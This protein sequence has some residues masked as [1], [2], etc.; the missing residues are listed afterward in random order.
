[1]APVGAESILEKYGSF[2]KIFFIQKSNDSYKDLNES[3]IA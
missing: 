2:Q 1:M 3:K